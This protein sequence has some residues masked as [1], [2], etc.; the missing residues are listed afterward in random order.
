M[1]T[2]APKR[3]EQWLSPA[4]AERMLAAFG[5][6]AVRYN[7]VGKPVQMTFCVDDDDALNVARNEAAKHP[8]RD[9]V[10]FRPCRILEG[11]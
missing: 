11:K 5:R 9:V 6:I 3:E 7:E 1:T 10:I 8:G 4:E 2:Q